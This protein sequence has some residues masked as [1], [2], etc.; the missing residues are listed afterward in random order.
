MVTRRS[1]FAALS[2]LV[3]GA[4]ARNADGRFGCSVLTAEL[5]LGFPA[6]C[7]LHGFAFFCRREK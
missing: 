7:F 6:G 1:A 3:A 4:G 2:G 5:V